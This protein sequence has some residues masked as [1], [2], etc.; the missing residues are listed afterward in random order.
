MKDK[1]IENFLQVLTQE[2]AH[3]HI[4]PESYSKIFTYAKTGINITAQQQLKKAA[5]NIG[6]LS[7]HKNRGMIVDENLLTDPTISKKL[8]DMFITSPQPI[9][10]ENEVSSVLIQEDVQL[11]ALRL[12]HELCSRFNF[13]VSEAHPRGSA[14]RLAQENRELLEENRK[15]REQSMRTGE[16]KSK[17][18]ELL[19]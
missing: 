1:H 14:A 16:L 5:K 18:Q 11:R 19:K 12:I 17:L 9:S 6:L 3:S 4:I 13:P 7:V 2:C 15:L 10:E 8:K